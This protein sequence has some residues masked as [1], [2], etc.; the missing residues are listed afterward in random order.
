VNIPVV[1]SCKIRKLTPRIWMMFLKMKHTDRRHRLYVNLYTG[2]AWKNGWEVSEIMTA[3]KQK[4]GYYGWVFSDYEKKKTKNELCTER[5][6]L[7]EQCIRIVRN[8]SKERLRLL[9][10]QNV[11][12]EEENVSRFSLFHKKEKKA[13]VPLTDYPQ[14]QK[15]EFLN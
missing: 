3:E 2:I 11:I 1:E 12:Y 5:N 13:F 6:H 10:Y 8:Y 7:A 4:D 14:P 9:S 15:V